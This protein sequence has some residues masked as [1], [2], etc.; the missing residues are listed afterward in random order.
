[1]K[2]ISKPRKSATKPEPP[3]DIT[4]QHARAEARRLIINAVPEITQALID[5]AKTGNYLPARMLFDFAALTAI[6]D[7]STS[8]ELSPIVKMLMDAL[9]LKPPAPELLRQCEAA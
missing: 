3:P 1:M 9:Q 7:D 6:A 4:E 2:K 5:Q 8:T